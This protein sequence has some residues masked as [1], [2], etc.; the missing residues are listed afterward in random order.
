[1]GFIE[2][3]FSY[4]KLR[5]L[6]SVAANTDTHIGRYGREVSSEEAHNHSEESRR[7]EDD[8]QWLLGEI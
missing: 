8:L 4:R 6:M 5:F 2:S 7:T 1:M 3:W